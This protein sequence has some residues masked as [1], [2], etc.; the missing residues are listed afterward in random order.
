MDKPPSPN[1]NWFMSLIQGTTAVPKSVAKLLD[2]VCEQIGLFLEPIHIRRKGQAESDL[3][4]AEAK[5]KAAIAVVRIENKDAIQDFEDRIEERLRRREAKRQAT[6][7]AI[8]A[9]AVQ[10]IPES[11]SEQ[12]VDEDWTARFFESCEDVNDEQMRLLWARILAGEVAK[13]GS[14]SCNRSRPQWQY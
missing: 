11:V 3:S 9:Q 12:P 1:P 5:A 4:L 13:P 2:T 10:E 8:T 14:F 6:R 7:E